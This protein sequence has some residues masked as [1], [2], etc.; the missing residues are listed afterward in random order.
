MAED[1]NIP[2][3]APGV[4]ATLPPAAKSGIGK[5][6]NA[7][8]NVAF[9]IGQGTLN[10]V[11]FPREDNA[12]VRDM[13]FIVTDGDAFFS[14]ERSDT[15][16]ETNWMKEGVPAFHIVNSCREERYRIEKEIITDPLRDTLLQQIIFNQSSKFRW[17]ESNLYVLLS[18]H[19]NNDGAHNNGWKGNYHGIPML[20]ARRDHTTLA[21]ACSSHFL[22][23]SIG[24]AGVSDGYTDLKQHHRMD[25]EYQKADD[26]NIM[27]TAQLD[28]GQSNKI[29]LAIGFGSTSE[30]AAHQAWSSLQDGFDLAKDRYIYEW[31]KWQR[32]LKNIK[33]DRNT[34]GRN[35]RTS[36]AVLRIHDS[37]N[38]PGG[39]IAS[40]STP[41]GQ[42]KKY[43]DEG[44]YHLVWPR[45]LALSSGGFLE[46]ETKDNLLRVLNYL[47]STQKPD[48]SWSQNMWLEGAS[49]WE[50]IQMDQIA[51]AILLVH[52]AFHKN[53]LDE[54]RIQR[55]W[56]IVKKAI[57]YLI[58]NGPATQQD[59]WEEESGIT[60]FT[61][62]AE[63]AA[64]LAGADLAEANN[65]KG[66]AN[67][68]RET[69]DFWNENIEQW[70]YATGTDISKEVGVDGYYIRINPT[71][72]PAE[73]IK[74]TF[75][76]LKNHTGDEGKILFGNLISV[77]ALA[78]V[79]FGLRAADDPRILNTLTAIDAKLKVDT[80]Y[81][82][83]WRRYVNDG[84]GEDVNGDF[85]KTHGIG[86]AWPL[87][88]GERGHYEIAAG[89]IDPAKKLLKAMELFS[90]NSLLPE[91]IWDT[92]DIPE[93]GL[94]FGKASGSAMPLTWAHAEYIKLCSSIKK[95]K[96]CDMPLFT[97]DRYIRQK[98]S[99]PYAVWRFNLRQKFISFGK[100]LRIEVLEEAVIRWT[101][102][103]WETW[104]NTPTRNSGLGIYVADIFTDYANKSYIRFTFFWKQAGHWEDKDFEIKVENEQVLKQTKY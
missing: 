104:E 89:N 96:I 59:R 88:T 79:R 7:N 45:D 48:G 85:S 36:A 14:E 43:M 17:K 54:E 46:L 23:S 91:Q 99:S 11:F 77:D 67:Y 52:S 72:V 8:S 78:L 15:Y 29:I 39:I 25:W 31:Q 56:R 34:I 9:T 74:K 100:I 53:F 83:C 6:V 62:S 41:W 32:L 28:I 30:D 21:L 103:N 1:T 58:K 24:Y 90:N 98:T 10:E 93:K 12:C 49:Y 3:G 2:P 68:C 5:A 63:I 33:S 69:A 102:N 81:G 92:N 61:L 60:P 4:P 19:I 94:F 20:F 35:F 57:A 66:M 84:Y 64:L 97:K 13:Q 82:P 70:L 55:Y 75:I 86:R 80:P 51:L 38:F 18:P 73:E 37:K 87:L 27:L 42:A 44:G 50:G 76:H 47:M 95:K 26:G 16:H 22:K 101:D 65:E 40:L 71:G